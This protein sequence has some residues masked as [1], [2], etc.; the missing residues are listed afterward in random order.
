MVEGGGLENRCTVR[1]RGFESCSLRQLIIQDSPKKDKNPL[2]IAGFY[3]VIC[4]KTCYATYQ[5]P[6]VLGADYPIKGPQR[7]IASP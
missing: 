7:Q 1:Y 5:N 4:P 2:E 3:L 6:A